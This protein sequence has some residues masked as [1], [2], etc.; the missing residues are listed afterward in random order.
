MSMSAALG[1][2]NCG[3]GRF[4]LEVG[5]YL[6]PERTCFETH[7]RKRGAS[8]NA[9]KLQQALLTVNMGEDAN[10]DPRYCDNLLP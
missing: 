10:A 5:Q 8:Y 9:A 7:R 2:A 1:L 4:E 6:H 3:G